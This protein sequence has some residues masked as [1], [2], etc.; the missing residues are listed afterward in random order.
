[1]LSAAGLKH[2]LDGIKIDLFASLT[3]RHCC[4][5]LII[6]VPII[7]PTDFGLNYLGVRT[8]KTHNCRRKTKKKTTTSKTIN[9]RKK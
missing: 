3:C 7:L 5:Y 2:T 9:K 1:M 6:N 4:C 8:F